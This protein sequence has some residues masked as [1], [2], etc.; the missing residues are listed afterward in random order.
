MSTRNAFCRTL[1]NRP[2]KLFIGLTGGIASGKSAAALCFAEQGATVINADRIAARQLACGAPSY[3][4]VT[5]RYG[6]KALLPDG[7][8]NR[9]FLAAKV[10]SDKTTRNWLESLIHPA[11]LAEIWKQAAG[12][13]TRL[14]VAEIPLLFETGSQNSFDFVVCLRADKAR[15]AKR[16]RARGWSAAELKRREAAQL[17]QER[18]CALSDIV[19]ANNGTRA[20][21]RKRIAALSSALETLC[22]ARRANNYRPCRAVACKTRKEQCKK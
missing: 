13:K 5:E 12:S 4:A 7:N 16:V 21:L 6:A 19:V 9:R 14:T 20:D 10:F 2:G 3:K 15:R 22:A 17:S 1:K 8:V 11:V 18:K